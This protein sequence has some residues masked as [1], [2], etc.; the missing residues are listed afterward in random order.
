MSLKRALLPAAVAAAMAPVSTPRVP[1]AS[2]ELLRAC[3][4]SDGSVPM[5]ERIQS[6]P[7]KKPC[8]FNNP[9]Y[10]GTCKVQPAEDETCASILA[11]LNNPMA[12]GK[13]YCG[14]TTVRQGWTEVS[15]EERSAY[16][17]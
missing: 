16:G 8:C 14:G 17:P 2:A 10:S 5:A 7:T 11:Y 3:P 4:N 15:C 12:E 6:E 1:A 13:S 9:A